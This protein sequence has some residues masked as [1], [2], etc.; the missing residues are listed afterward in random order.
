MISCG[1]VGHRRQ[2]KK[3]ERNINMECT[4]YSTNTTFFSPLW[5]DKT[6]KNSSFCLTPHIERIIVI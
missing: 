4:D 2:K 3:C 6:V 1:C 5:A